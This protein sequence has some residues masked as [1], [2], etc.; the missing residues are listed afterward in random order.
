M[1]PEAKSRG[2]LKS[3]GG[4]NLTMLLKIYRVMNL[5]LYGKGGVGQGEVK[6]SK[7][8]ALCCND[9]EEF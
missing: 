1:F 7:I 6:L 8:S 9:Q 5:A 2:I 4:G 3:R